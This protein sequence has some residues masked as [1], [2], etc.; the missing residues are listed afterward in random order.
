MT[1]TVFILDDHE[2]VR[3]G[4]REILTEA[5]GIEIV[6]ESGLAREAARRI[7]ALRP[8]VALLDARLPDGS[9]IEVC[10]EIRSRD[11]SIHAIILTSYDDNEALTASVLAGA[12]GY[13]LKQIHGPDLAEA[14]RRV[15]AGESLMDRTTAFQIPAR[16][17]E[18]NR[19][20]N[21]PMTELTPQEE[22]VLDLI[23]EGLTNRQIG[24]RLNIAEKT[25]KNHVTSL[26]AKLHVERR[27]QAAVYGARIRGFGR[28]WS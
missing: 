4:L 27:T 5:G 6:G 13:I 9:G 7:P 25:V 16:A 8:D 11:P 10:R 12:S 22:R 17:T 3:R 28:R 19:R 14:V 18:S 21:H 15:A 20:N 23:V 2:L 26:M 1:V 24:Q